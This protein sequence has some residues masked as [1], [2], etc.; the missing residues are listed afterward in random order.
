[1]KDYAWHSTTLRGIARLTQL[2]EA[3]RQRNHFLV[4]NSS[5]MRLLSSTLHSFCSADNNSFGGEKMGTGIY[6]TMSIATLLT[7]AVQKPWSGKNILLLHWWS[8]WIKVSSSIWPGVLQEINFSQRPLGFLPVCFF[9][10]P[11]RSAF[12]AR[13]IS[14]AHT[15]I[16]PFFS[17][18]D[19]ISSATDCQVKSCLCMYASLGLSAVPRQG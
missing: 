8:K 6:F 2:M 9:F 3:A 7:Q 5:Y 11:R 17:S 13:K 19:S 15:K 10:P 18:G 4:I 16:S 14:T 12:V 1:M